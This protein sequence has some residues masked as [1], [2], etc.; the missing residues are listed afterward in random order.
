M[1]GIEIAQVDREAVESV[2]VRYAMTAARG[3]KWDVVSRCDF[4]LNLEINT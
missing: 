4:H 2:V 1:D 3:E